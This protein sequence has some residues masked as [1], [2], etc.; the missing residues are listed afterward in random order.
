MSVDHPEKKRPFSL[1]RVGYNLL[2]MLIFLDG[3][4]FL[5][6]VALRQPA[7]QQRLPYGLEITSKL[8]DNIYN[9]PAF[10]LQK[11][12]DYVA[13]YGAVDCIIIGSSLIHGGINTAMFEQR[14]ETETGKTLQCFN[15]GADALTASS[16][17]PI[18]SVLA[19]IYHPEWVIWGVSGSEFTTRNLTAPTHV[20]EDEYDPSW[21]DYKL[22]N[23]NVQGWLMENSYVF[24][25]IKGVPPRLFVKTMPK[26]VTV[27]AEADDAKEKRRP[28][29]HAVTAVSGERPLISYES[30]SPL[31]TGIDARDPATPL[32]PV[33]VTLD[34]EDWNA[35]DALIKRS[36]DE[37][38]Q[39]IMFEIPLDYAPDDE[40]RV[41]LQLVS[42]YAR[43]RD[44]PFLPT[45]NLAPLP[46][47]AYADKTH[48][49][50]SG[51]MQFSAWLGMQ[52]GQ[53][54]QQ[55]AIADVYA[56]LWTPS[57]AQWP[58]PFYYAT[59]GLSDETYQAYVTSSG[60]FDLMP[61]DAALFNPSAIE[62][63]RLFLQ[64]NIGLYLDWATGMTA[65]K[66]VYYF[67]LL[68]VL[69]K[70]NYPTEMGFDDGQQDQFAGWFE[71]PH[72]EVMRSLGIDYLLCRDELLTPD[73][74]HCPDLSRYPAY[75]MIASWKYP[76]LYDAYTLYRVTNPQ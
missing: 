55:G 56:P 2:L 23:S 73:H 53:A 29:Y 36:Q 12:E 75:T 51:S 20:A 67:D 1:A 47:S 31:F 54:V 8:S 41:V 70:M 48:M 46:P 37:A 18:A 58:E 14:F 30:S 69:G 13:R 10:N 7:I 21:L 38:W 39:L 43:E 74:A 72:P 76:P 57:L 66:R 71:D 9:P 44:V 40:R 33:D 68:T 35:F 45:W 61:E 15:F 52:V 16:A 11:L 22:G 19:E 4:L 5:G 3:A 24:R 63:D 62:L 27:P 50:I 32:V 17:G 65:S 34:E 26:E 42:D 59:L 6:E 60:G 25:F 28:I 64:A 49:H